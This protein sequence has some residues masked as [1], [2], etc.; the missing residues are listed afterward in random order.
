MDS[1]TLNASA[2]SLGPAS[3]LFLALIQSLTVGQGSV[4]PPEMWPQD[5]GP[6]EAGNF[7]FAALV[8]A[9]NVAS[10]T[11]TQKCPCN[12]AHL[13]ANC[14][15]RWRAIRFYRGRR[16]IGRF[17][18]GESTNGEFGVEGAVAGGRRQSAGRV[19]GKCFLPSPPPLSPQFGCI[20]RS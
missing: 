11:Q 5:S 3:Q 4:S 7:H 13:G 19:R 18:G 8:A 2:T 1:L 10:C 14:S 20:D 12:C 6:F 9:A 17:S 16:R 15:H